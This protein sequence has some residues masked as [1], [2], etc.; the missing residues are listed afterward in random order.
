[1]VNR[2]QSVGCTRFF[3]YH[4]DAFFGLSPADAGLPK[5]RSNELN[6][7]SLSKKREN[8]GIINKLNN[9]MA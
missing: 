1:M 7:P 4:N 2:G 5:T 8:S 6:Y 9:D 3:D